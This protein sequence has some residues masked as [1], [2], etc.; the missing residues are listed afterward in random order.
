MLYLSVS[1]VVQ[2]IAYVE[3]ITIYCLDE[4]FFCFLRCD[5]RCNFRPCAVSF[6]NCC[7]FASRF[8][9]KYQ[10]SS[11]KCVRIVFFQRKQQ[12]SQEYISEWYVSIPQPRLICFVRY[13]PFLCNEMVHSVHKI[14]IIKC[15][16]LHPFKSL[17]QFRKTH[18]KLAW[19]WF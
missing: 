16:H 14:V 6:F 9:Y 1:D 19:E 12:Y 18:G 13:I 4:Y 15:I 3:W 11:P 2:Y 10:H 7:Y 17:Q 8:S 5:F